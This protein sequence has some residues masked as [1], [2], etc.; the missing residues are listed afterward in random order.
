MKVI[1]LGLIPEFA[2]DE[3]QHATYNTAHL[4]HS[5]LKILQ[6]FDSNKNV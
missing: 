4:H 3:M 1:M 5:N 2:W 6:L